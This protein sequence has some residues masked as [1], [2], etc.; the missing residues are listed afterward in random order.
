MKHFVL[1]LLALALSISVV[2]AQ[3]NRIYIED[4]E[5]EPG[6]TDTVPVLLS[7]VDPSRGL[8]FNIS[9][10]DGLKIAGYEVTDY[11]RSYTMSMSCNYSQKDSCYMVFMY[12]SS[13]VCYPADTAAVVMFFELRALDTFRGGDLITW[14]C[15]GSTLDNRT[16]YMEGD[17]THVTVPKASI[18]GIPMDQRPVKDLYFDLTGQQINSPDSVPVAICVRTLADGR[19]SSC[20]VAV[21]H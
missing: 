15:R 9:L 18:I 17:T 13:Y 21:R 8:Q 5:I 1:T 11:S 20:K 2:A 6:E 12:P 4:F 7:N 19:R 3:G 14:K 10:P 16:I